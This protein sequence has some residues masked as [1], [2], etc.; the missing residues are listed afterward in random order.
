MRTVECKRQD[1]TYEST[2]MLLKLIKE[3]RPCVYQ[4]DSLE[5]M[6]QM[7]KFIV[8]TLRNKNFHFDIRQAQIRWS[9]LKMIYVESTLETFGLE[10]YEE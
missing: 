6:E 5:S 7:W 9:N 4:I 3:Y 8:E 2:K 1:W 10:C